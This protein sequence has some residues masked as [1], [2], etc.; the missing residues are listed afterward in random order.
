MFLRLPKKTLNIFSAGVVQ[1]FVVELLP[2]SPFLSLK[3]AL[4]DAIS[5]LNNQ[6]MCPT[7]DN[8]REYLKK[9]YPELKVKNCLH[10]IS[11]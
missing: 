1:D 5:D 6:K 8:L 2:Q 3:T 7:K 4:F 11:L 9:H 10:I